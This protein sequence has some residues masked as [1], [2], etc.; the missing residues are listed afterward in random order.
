MNRSHRHETGRRI[1]EAAI[2]SM[3]GWRRWWSMGEHWLASEP[4]AYRNVHGN[5][6]LV[7]KMIRRPQEKAEGST[8]ASSFLP[9]FVRAMQPAASGFSAA[10]TER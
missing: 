4:F 9:G 3:A 8:C 7:M 6:K 5:A 10:G 2:P 1:K